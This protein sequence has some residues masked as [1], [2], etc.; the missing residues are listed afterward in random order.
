MCYLFSKEKKNLDFNWNI[1][2]SHIELKIVCMKIQSN[3][4]N[5]NT[6]AIIKMIDQKKF[7]K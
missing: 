1:F 7:N 3:P 2:V 6:L 4:V 5:Y